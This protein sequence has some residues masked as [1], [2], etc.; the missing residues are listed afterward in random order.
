[1]AYV[2]VTAP[3][4]TVNAIYLWTGGPDQAVMRIALQQGQRLAHRGGQGAA[5]Q[6]AAGAAASPG[7]A[8]LLERDG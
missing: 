5:A 2:G 6:G 8:E 4:Y 1:M 7:C 3:T